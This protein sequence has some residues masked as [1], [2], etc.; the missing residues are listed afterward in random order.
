ML[1]LVNIF[2]RKPQCEKCLALSCSVAAYIECPHFEISALRG[3]LATI[4]AE[5]EIAINLLVKIYG[6]ARS[7]LYMD[8]TQLSIEAHPVI[9]KIENYLIAQGRIAKD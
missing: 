9:E 1:R 6:V 4:Q 3:E 2:D 7:G 8:A 5:S